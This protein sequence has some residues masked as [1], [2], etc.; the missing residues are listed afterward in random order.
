MYFTFQ[1]CSPTLTF[2]EDDAFSSV[3][4]KKNTFLSI[5][6]YTLLKL[7]QV[8]SFWMFNIGRSTT[9]PGKDIAFV[10]VRESF[11][12][13]TNPEKVT[14]CLRL[15][16]IRTQRRQVETPQKFLP[17]NFQRKNYHCL[18]AVHVQHFWPEK[19]KGFHH[20]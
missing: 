19:K 4:K 8:P 3:P 9:S 13:L 5:T 2:V 15:M 12:L 14:L 11:H 18:H 17:R 16:Q 6:S 20:F 10:G 7:M 1:L